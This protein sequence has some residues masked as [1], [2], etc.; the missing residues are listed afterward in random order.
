[1]TKQEEIRELIDLYTDDECLY[2]NKDCESRGLFNYCRL[3]NDAYKCLMKRLGEKGVVLK[4][5][6]PLPDISYHSA[7]PENEEA[8][9]QA[10]LRAGYVATEPLIKEDE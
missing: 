4:V 2:P 10:I 6:A 3:G 9:Q 7:Y 8:Y 5:A 1:M